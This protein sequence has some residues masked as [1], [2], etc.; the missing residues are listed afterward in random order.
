MSRHPTPKGAAE[1][2]RHSAYMPPRFARTAG[3][4]FKDADYAT[5]IHRPAGHV[6]GSADA[7]LAWLA[8]LLVVVA[9]VLSHLGGPSDAQA[10]ADTQADLAAAIA[11]AQGERPEL[12]D[13]ASRARAEVAVQ[14]V[15]RGGV[16]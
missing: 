14:L 13:E 12:W 3:Q 1:H 8:V 10:E 6:W 7:A 5:A 4:A 11:Q 9:F 16:R 2:S 15:A